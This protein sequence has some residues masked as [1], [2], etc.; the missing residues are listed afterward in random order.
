MGVPFPFLVG[1]SRPTI[2]SVSWD[3]FF[4]FVLIFEHDITF[5]DITRFNVKNPRKAASL[6]SL[7]QPVTMA[8]TRVAYRDDARTRVSIAWSVRGI[9]SN[10]RIKCPATVG[11]VYLFFFFIEHCTILIYFYSRR[12][13]PET[14]RRAHERRKVTRSFRSMTL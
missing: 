6:S 14:H 5:R 2:K 4:N 9:S 1:T 13:I 12:A 10:A 3:S 11:I 8:S 7:V